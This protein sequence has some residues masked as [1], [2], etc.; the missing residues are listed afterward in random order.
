[1]NNTRFF[2]NL[3]KETSKF[4]SK[5]NSTTAKCCSV[6]R[7]AKRRFQLQQNG[8]QGYSHPANADRWKIKFRWAS[9]QDR[10]FCKRE[11]H[12]YSTN[13]QILTGR[14]QGFAY[15]L[16]VCF[17]QDHDGEQ[18]AKLK[19]VEDVLPEVQG[20]E[21]ILGLCKPSARL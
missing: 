18:V 21:H 5:A 15:Y 20:V 10:V 3:L 11:I 12:T 13:N 19:T 8:S 16:K 1:M 2:Y 9:H 6:V 14:I 17:L 7:K 4:K